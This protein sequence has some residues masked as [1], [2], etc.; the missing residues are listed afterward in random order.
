MSLILRYF[1]EFGSLWAHGVKVV[2]KVVV[3]R[4]HIRYLIS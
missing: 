1:T 3:K 4:V 2:E